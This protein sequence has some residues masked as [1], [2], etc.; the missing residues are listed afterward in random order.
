MSAPFALSNQLIPSDSNVGRH[1]F[2]YV[3][4]VCVFHDYRAPN[5]FKLVM[6]RDPVDAVANAVRGEAPIFPLFGCLPF[7]LYRCDLEQTR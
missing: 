1:R 2:E 4:T 5:S 6:T 7:I 3:L